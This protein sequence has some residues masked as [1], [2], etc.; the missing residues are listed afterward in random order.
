MLSFPREM[1]VVPGRM[2]AAAP[3]LV[4]GYAP[5]TFAQEPTLRGPFA[6]FFDPGDV[7]EEAAEIGGSVS[8]IPTTVADA[9][10]A[11]APAVAWWWHRPEYADAPGASVA[12]GRQADIVQATHAYENAY[13]VLAWVAMPLGNRVQIS[14]GEHSYIVDTHGSGA[15]RSIALPLGR[16]AN[17]STVSIAALDGVSEVELRAFTI[18][19]K[20]DYDRRRALWQRAYRKATVAAPLVPKVAAISSRFGTGLKLGALKRGVVYRLSIEG[21]NSPDYVADARGFLMA[22]LGRAHRA[23]FIASGLPVFLSGKPAGVRWSLEEL[24]QH[25]ELPSAGAPK[26]AIALWNSAYSVEW[27][28]PGSLRHLRSAIGTNIFELPDRLHK[29]DVVFSRAPAFHLAYI[30]G[31]LVLLVALLLNVLFRAAPDLQKEI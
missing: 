13:G 3:A 27:Q 22:N 19:E 17:G 12:F 16:L 30:V 31:C 4:Q 8:P 5:V 29:E 20:S 2:T 23:D 11:F 24:R 9:R 28:L 7:P 14:V 26:E 15:W 6:F 25:T 10:A 21:P 1:A 18:I